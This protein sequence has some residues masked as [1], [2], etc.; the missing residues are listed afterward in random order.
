MN[1]VLGK[2]PMCAFW[3]IGG[4]FELGAEYENR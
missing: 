4:E 3:V 1:S 2:A